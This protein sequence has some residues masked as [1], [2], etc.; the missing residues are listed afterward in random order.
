M[1]IESEQHV[2]CK[3]FF[4]VGGHGGFCVTTIW[5]CEF[6]VG[7]LTMKTTCDLKRMVQKA[8]GYAMINV[9]ILKTK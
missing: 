3:L 1:K 2:A 9:P 8:Y 7:T 4:V 6:L 5:K